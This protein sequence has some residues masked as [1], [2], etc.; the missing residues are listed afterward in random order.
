MPYTHPLR[1][2][3]IQSWDGT[4]WQV[5]VALP[6][7][8]RWPTVPFPTGDGIPTL[9]ARRKA[10]AT[11]GYAPLTGDAAWDWMETPLEGEP[12]GTIALVATTTVAP[13]DPK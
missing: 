10:L 12:T 7:T 5:F 1:A 8:A 4:E 13:A 11:L 3:M 9:T 6:D 2:H